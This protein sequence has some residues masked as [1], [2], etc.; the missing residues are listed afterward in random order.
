MKTDPDYMVWQSG[1][2]RAL[3][4]HFDSPLQVDKLIKDTETIWTGV[5]G[6][7]A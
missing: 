2:A 6:Y 4:L 1:S 3:S 7:E 5:R